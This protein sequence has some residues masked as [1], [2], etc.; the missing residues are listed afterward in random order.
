MTE[1]DGGSD[2]KPDGPSSGQVV[3]MSLLAHLLLSSI[4]RLLDPFSEESGSGLEVRPDLVLSHG[5][6][7]LDLCRP[8]ASSHLPARLL[9]V[10]SNPPGC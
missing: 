4:Q 1:Q 3:E 2:L 7:P 6:R 8:A 9:G 5:A 10:L